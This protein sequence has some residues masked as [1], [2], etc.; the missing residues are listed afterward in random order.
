MLTL[1]QR[2]PWWWTGGWALVAAALAAAGLLAVGWLTEP[3]PDPPLALVVAKEGQPAGGWMRLPAPPEPAPWSRLDRVATDVATALRPVDREAQ[4]AL[5]RAARLWA[6]L[7][8]PV[9]PDKS[10]VPGIRCAASPV[11]GRRP[12]RASR[13]TVHSTRWPRDPV[14]AIVS[15]TR[16]WYNS[17]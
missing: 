3:A 4:L 8:I 1:M 2:Q 17:I 13:R 14:V 9:A 15:A 12:D 11:M 7:P 10:P 16:A 5:Q 6:R